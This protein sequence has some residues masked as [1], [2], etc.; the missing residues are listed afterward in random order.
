M[1]PPALQ[2]SGPRPKRAKA[3]SKA[4]SVIS[5]IGCGPVDGTAP[6]VV[7]PP[8]TST[9]DRSKAAEEAFSGVLSA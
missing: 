6:E 3:K 7:L 8:F 2:K 1:R 9:Y 5:A 4:S